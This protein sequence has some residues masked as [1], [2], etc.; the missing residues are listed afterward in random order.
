MRGWG[1]AVLTLVVLT[2]VVARS[3]A[4]RA[5]SPILEQPRSTKVDLARARELDAQGARAYREGR[6]RDAL[7]LFTEA[8]RLGGPSLELWN[9]A[10]C[11]QRLDEDDDAAEVLVKYLEATDLSPADRVE[12]T[13]ELHELRRTSSMLLV[14]SSVAGATVLIDGRRVGIAPVAVEV[15]PGRHMVRVVDAKERP[16]DLEV[17]ARLGRPIVVRAMAGFEELSPAAEP[18]VTRRLELDLQGGVSVHAM[19]T[20]AGRVS[21]GLSSGLRFAIGDRSVTGFVAVRGE[22]FGLGWSTT[23]AILNPKLPQC[24]LPDRY[25]ATALSGTLGGGVAWDATR[26]VRASLELGVG[27][28][29]MFVSRGGG[30]VL[31]PSCSPSPGLVPS[32]SARASV[33]F[34]LGGGSRIALTPLAF[35]IHPAYDGARSDPRDASG[36]WIRLGGTVGLAYDVGL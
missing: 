31:M 12:A 34:R 5:A 6:T 1:R 22:F 26:V 21:P 13:R 8:Y 30:D 18:P 3:S 28:E 10:R 2:W 35:A 7:L 29:G 24:V 19:G 25:Q 23:G 17:E 20:V 33:S 27:A 15:G 32:G 16:R 4:A 9:V 11:H 36:A 14:D